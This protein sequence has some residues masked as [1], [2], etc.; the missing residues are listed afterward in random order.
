MNELVFE[1]VIVHYR[2]PAAVVDLLRSID[3]WGSV[4]SVV[5][6]AD[7]SRD[8]EL[9]ALGENDLT[10]DV[11]VHRMPANVGYGPAI[12]RAIEHVRSDYVLVLTQDAWLD[13]SAAGLLGQA[14]ASDGGV[15]VAAPLLTFRSDGARV[16]S[17]GGRLL[18]N[19]RTLHARQNE[20]VDDSMDSP[21]SYRVQWADGACF[22]VRVEDFR[23][24]GGFDEQFF[25]YV[26]EV[27]LHLRLQRA[28]RSIVLIPRARAAQEPGN[29]TLY[30]KYRNLTYFTRKHRDIMRPW[31]WA[32]AFPK[33]AM[34]MASMGRPA[35]FIWALKGLVDSARGTM[36]RKPASIFLR[37]KS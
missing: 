29:Y 34:R 13:R 16:F 7:N 36:G 12:N 30:Y 6:V 3:T 26:E 15:A 5:H 23:L 28:G 37:R 35:E 14:L 27:D 20:R 19:G 2:D 18:K 22:M 25:L 17:A 10:F 21:S 32:V 4:P 9:D 31:P 33:D 1:A 11:E 24:V 8:F